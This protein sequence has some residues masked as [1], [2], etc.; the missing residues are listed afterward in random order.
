MGPARAAEDA[1]V[2]RK[3]LDALA[4]LV[5][6]AGGFHAHDEGQRLAAVG[7]GAHARLGEVHA[8]RA[9]AHAHLAGAG[10]GHGQV[11]PVHHIE[12]TKFS[13]DPGFQVASLRCTSSTSSP[14]GNGLR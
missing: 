2:H 11:L 9:H 6:H 10:L 14:E 5:D 1:L 12:A 4:E 13:D 3:A 7:A 8:G